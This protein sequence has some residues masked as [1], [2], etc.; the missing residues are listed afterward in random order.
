MNKIFF[1]LKYV[2]T[3]IFFGFVIWVSFDRTEK[4]LQ[5]FSDS[6]LC[7]TVIAVLIIMVHRERLLRQSKTKTM[8]DRIAKLE[9]EINPTRTS[10]GQTPTD[11][12]HPK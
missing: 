3:L 10:S 4:I 2:I 6:W 12:T 8:S 5:I 1:L 11:E 9:A 7:W